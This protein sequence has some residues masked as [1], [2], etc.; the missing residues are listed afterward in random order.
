[1]R[2]IVAVPGC[3][4]T[5]GH[6]G[7]RPGPEGSARVAAAHL[8]LDDAQRV[9]V[10]APGDLAIGDLGESAAKLGRDLQL[11]AVDDREA[12]LPPT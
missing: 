10:A 3:P 11:L 12:E 9:I 1:M 6:A 8:R 2:H 7:R 4:G 5:G